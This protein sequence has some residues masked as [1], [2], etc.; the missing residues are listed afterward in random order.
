ML[1]GSLLALNAGPFEPG[2]ALVAYAT[3]FSSLILH[4]FW[5]RQL[6]TGVPP[7]PDTMTRWE[8][9]LLIALITG[10][11][12]TSVA[13]FA[14]PPGEL[15]PPPAVAQPSAVVAGMAAVVGLAT[16]ALPPSPPAIL[17]PLTGTLATVLQHGATLI[18]FLNAFLLA[19]ILVATWAFILLLI[20][21]LAWIALAAT[22]E[23]LQILYAYHQLNDTP[24]DPPT[25][26]P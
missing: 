14:V 13:S 15:V 26:I 9:A 19:V 21:F 23:Y 4:A 18:I 7:E 12:G 6:A 17:E 5:M 11:I 10:V 2:A 24:P 16:L 22:I 20:A 3:G 8:A 1:A 25:I